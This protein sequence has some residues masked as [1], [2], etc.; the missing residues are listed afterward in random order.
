MINPEKFG[1]GCR[2]E[3]SWKNL[4]PG[5]MFEKS[6]NQI[7]CQHQVVCSEEEE[8][9]NLDLNLDSSHFHGQQLEIPPGVCFQFELWPKKGLI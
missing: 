4:K 5:Q 2:A 3:Q 6:K 8:R 9:S 7:L 1:R